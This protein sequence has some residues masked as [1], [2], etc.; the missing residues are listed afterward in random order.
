MV[1]WCGLS[2]NLFCQ[3]YFSLEGKTKTCFSAHSPHEQRTTPSHGLPSPALARTAHPG[4]RAQ[5]H[6]SSQCC[7]GFARL[8][9]ARE[10]NNVTLSRR[11]CQL[12][13]TA[14]CCVGSAISTLTMTVQH[15]QLQPL[16]EAPSLLSQ[17]NAAPSLCALFVESQKP[18]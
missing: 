3:I 10:G 1:C 12:T 6:S 7:D 14:N 5:T 17:Y 15:E 16:A 2:I 4:S 18:D 9:T 8:S 11:V 13:L